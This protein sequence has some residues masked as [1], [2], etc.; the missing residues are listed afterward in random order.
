MVVV[1]VFNVVGVMVAVNSEIRVFPKATGYTPVDDLAFVGSPPRE[2][3][4]PPT[5]LDVQIS[6][7]WTWDIPIAQ[8]L[9]IEWMKYYKNVNIGGPAFNDPGGNFIPGKFVRRGVVFTS[10]GC[11]RRCPWCYIHK[12]EGNIRE[13]KIFSGF[14]IEDSNL[15]MCSDNHIKS[16]F[17]MLRKN[18]NESFFNG[19]FEARLFKRW[20]IDLLDSINVGEIFFACDSKEALP[21]LKK[22]IPLLINKPQSWKCCYVLLNYNETMQAGRQR[23]SEVKKIGFTPIPMLYQSN[24]FIHHKSGWLDLLTEFFTQTKYMQ[25]VDCWQKEC[26]I[27]NQEQAKR[28]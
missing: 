16:V 10:R 28:K 8:K 22:I 24:R 3:F 21:Y 2:N 15:L 23:I 17:K 19:G 1:F 4:L 13:L 26:L 14:V 6:V 27:K 18:G 11:N 12:R 5:S 9:A 20:H 7:V 25:L